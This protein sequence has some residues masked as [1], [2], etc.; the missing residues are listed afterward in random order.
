MNRKIFLG[1]I[2]FV[3]IIAL[4]LVVRFLNSEDVWLCEN[5]IWVKHGHPDS[6]PPA[7]IC[8]SERGCSMEAKMCPD[9][10]SVGRVCPDCE[11][12]PCPGALDDLAGTDD[13]AGH[14]GLA[15]PASQNCLDLG[16]QLSMRK[17]ENGE[18]GVCL[19]EDNR[20][21]EEWALFRGECPVG[22]IKITG[23]D[24]DA[25]IYC[26]ITGGQVEA[27]GTSRPMCRRSDGLYCPAEDNLN[28]RCD[29]TG[30]VQAD[31]LAP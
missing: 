30:S 26:A 23:Y 2:I 7:S 3:C 14:I 28:G 10:T 1:A 4:V 8:T 27:G 6:V 11:F 20:Q 15:N 21:C 13:G 24:S 19:F 9:G 12:A 29:L 25:E 22:G 31:L 18:Y 17:N 16:G 5:G